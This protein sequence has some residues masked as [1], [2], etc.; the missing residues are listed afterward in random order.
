VNTLFRVRE[1][2]WE[3]RSRS[4]SVV[5]LITWDEEY[6]QYYVSGGDMDYEHFRTFDEAASYAEV[7]S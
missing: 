6:E 7:A 5:G 1:F 4:G 2:T 3:V